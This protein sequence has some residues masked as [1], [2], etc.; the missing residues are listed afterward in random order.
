[1]AQS[2]FIEGNTRANPLAD[3]FLAET[4]RGDMVE[5]R[6]IIFRMLGLNHLIFFL[7]TCG[8]SIHVVIPEDDCTAITHTITA[9]KSAFNESNVSRLLW[10]A[11]ECGLELEPM[12]QH[13][14]PFGFCEQGI[15][16]FGLPHIDMRQ[17]LRGC[18]TMTTVEML[19]KIHRYRKHFDGVVTRVVLASTTFN[20]EP[21]LDESKNLIQRPTRLC[22]SDSG[23]AV[24]FEI[25][26]MLFTYYQSAS[27]AASSLHIIAMCLHFSLKTP[28]H[29]LRDVDKWD[30]HRRILPYL[31][32]K[33][34]LNDGSIIFEFFHNTADIDYLIACASVC[35]D[36]PKWP[37]ACVQL[38]DRFADC[39]DDAADVVAN[40]SRLPGM[41]LR[42]L[43]D[44]ANFVS[45]NREH[46]A[47]LLSNKLVLIVVKHAT[48][49]TEQIIE[50]VIE[51]LVY[52]NPDVTLV[53]AHRLFLT[54]TVAQRAAI[55]KRFRSTHR[56][57]PCGEIIY[58][59]MHG[60]DAFGT[61]SPNYNSLRLVLVMLEHELDESAIV[62]VIGATHMQDVSSVL[63]MS[64]LV[65]ALARHKLRFDLL[66]H[67]VDRHYH[68]HMPNRRATILLSELIKRS[69]F[70]EPDQLQT[71]I[72][73][74][75]QDT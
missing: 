39:D 4:T 2:T 42:S 35:R 38:I 34:D 57:T 31:L 24:W 26:D 18:P 21:I 52:D 41:K 22:A 56:D 50:C 69:P 72:A 51:W 43:T 13:M 65:L 6:R 55:Y 54:Q 44:I 71:L 19:T 28:M 23:S 5:F 73:C 32:S 68:V 36:H 27:P 46:G 67:L 8:N 61:Y 3:T 29:L 20:A 10:F 37:Q 33:P 9:K 45:A 70:Y 75:R 59:L 1:M 25:L 15:E 11:L 49:N 60:E 74:I 62:H 58:H 12:T 53:L 66:L 40:V 64:Y 30:K 16:H 17:S 63:G 47:H 7:E 48:H 14:T